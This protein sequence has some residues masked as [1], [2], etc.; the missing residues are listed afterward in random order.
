MTNSGLQVAESLALES[1]VNIEVVAIDL[2]TLIQ[3]LGGPEI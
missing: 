2:E 1:W 3:G